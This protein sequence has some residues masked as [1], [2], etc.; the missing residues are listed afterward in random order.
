MFKY[1]IFR[2]YRIKSTNGKF[3]A[4]YT[5]HF[6][7]NEQWLIFVKN[8]FC[9]YINVLPL[10]GYCSS[11]ATSSNAEKKRKGKGGKKYHKERTPITSP[12]QIR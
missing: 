4:F 12:R 3:V 10:S 2:N 1:S 6:H 7:L 8:S 11:K 5:V 9:I